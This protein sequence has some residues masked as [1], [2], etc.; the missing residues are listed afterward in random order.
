MSII[1]CKYFYVLI[2]IKTL[3]EVDKIGYTGIVKEWVQIKSPGGG[4]SGR[5]EKQG[6]QT[7]FGKRRCQNPAHYIPYDRSIL[8]ADRRSSKKESCSSKR[9]HFS[10][11][12]G[13]GLGGRCSSMIWWRIIWVLVVPKWF[14]KHLYSTSITGYTGF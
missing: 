7:V 3:T 13:K 6:R 1:I 14:Q 12:F 10:C 5:R 2:I 11:R 8:Q 4:I 9:I